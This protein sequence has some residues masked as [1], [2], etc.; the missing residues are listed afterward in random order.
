MRLN[1]RRRFGAAGNRPTISALPLVVAGIGL[2]ALIA[3]L[4]AAEQPLSRV[5]ALLALAGGSRPCTAFAAPRR[6]P[7]A[8]P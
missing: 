6:R 7:C 5:G 2:L 1:R 8:A 3:P 4:R